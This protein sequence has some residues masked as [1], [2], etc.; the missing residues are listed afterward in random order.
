MR[1][2]GRRPGGASRVRPA[3]PGW[4]ARWFSIPAGPGTSPCRRVQVEGLCSQLVVVPV[5]VP[6]ERA[7]A[8]KERQLRSDWPT[9]LAP[10]LCLAR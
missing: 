8:G 2:A 9:S 3:R 1:G 4:T 5:F 10:A 7:S 6:V